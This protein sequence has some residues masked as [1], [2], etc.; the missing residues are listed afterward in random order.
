MIV[1]GYNHKRS[2]D[3]AYAMEPGWLSWSVMQGTTHGS[4]YSY[5]T[6]VP[7]LFYGKGVPKGSSARFHTITDIAPTLSG[8]IKNKIS[9]WMYRST[10]Y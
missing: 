8:V 7:I 6:H 4:S 5:D 2:G 3:I 1:R 10:D 9:E